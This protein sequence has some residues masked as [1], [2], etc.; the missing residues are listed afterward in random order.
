MQLQEA[1]EDAAHVARVADQPKSCTLSF[2]RYR[3]LWVGQWG[4]G[5]KV[6]CQPESV[7]MCPH[8]YADI[9][10]NLDRDFPT[11]CEFCLQASYQNMKARQDGWISLTTKT[12]G[13]SVHQF[14][15]RGDDNTMDKTILPM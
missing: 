5:L 1:V 10:N 3:R 13:Q 7:I 2:Y 8:I 6:G 12:E 11:K 4:W 15:K 9:L 14:V